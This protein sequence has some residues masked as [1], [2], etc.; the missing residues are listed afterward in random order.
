MGEIDNTVVDV[1]DW[2]EEIVYNQVKYI[3]EKNGMKY[4]IPSILGGCCHPGV[5][6]ATYDA[7]YKYNME[8]FGIATKNN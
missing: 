7:V 1:D 6:Q 4:F 5:M 2:T 3:C 8:R